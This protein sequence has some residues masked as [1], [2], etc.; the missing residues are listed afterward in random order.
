MWK[1]MIW[2]GSLSLVAA[3][4]LLPVSAKA[5]TMVYT[6]EASFK[7]VLQTPYYLQ[8]FTG[9]AEGGGDA[10]SSAGNGYAYT[11]STASVYDSLYWIN[12]G[13]ATGQWTASILITFTGAPVTAVGGDFWLTD[14]DGKNLSGGIT[15]TLSDGTKTTINPS[16]FSTFTGLTT[17]DG[18]AFTSISIKAA[19][20]TVYQY[21]TINHL[22]VGADPAPVPEPSSLI[23]L[24]SG[25]V[26]LGFYASNRRWRK[27]Q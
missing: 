12:S 27:K 1:K 20:P 16:S 25:L 4:L 22:Y 26:G 14:V 13:L 15:L 21:P 17:T 7:A 6:D 2:F 9:H 8:D 3:L 11:V 23:L 24:G 10:F 18:P 19:T 5:T